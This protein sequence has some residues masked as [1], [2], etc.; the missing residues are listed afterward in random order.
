M[1]TLERQKTFLGVK[2]NENNAA[3]LNKFDFLLFTIGILCCFLLFT[4]EDIVTTGCNSLSY[5]QGVPWKFYSNNFNWYNGYAANY[6]PTI[7]LLFSIWN[8]PLVCLNFLLKK[9]VGVAILSSAW[10]CESVWVTYY[11]KL[12]P[13]LVFFLTGILL[14]RLCVQRLSFS[15][16]KAQICM[17]VFYTSPFAFFSQFVFCQYDILTVFFMV[18]GLFYYFEERPTEKDYAWFSLFFGIAMS[19]KYFAAVFWAALILVRVKDIIQIIRNGIICVAPFVIEATVYIIFDRQKFV[20]NVFNFPALDFAKAGF[21]I[22]GMLPI[23]LMPLALILMLAIAY[24]KEPKTFD[25][26]VHTALF[27]ACGCCFCFFGLMTFYPQ[28]LMLGVIFWTLG[29]C[30]HQHPEKFI[31]IDTFAYVAL[32]IFAVNVFK[33]GVDETMLKRGVL[34]HWL[35]FKTE[36]PVTMADIFSKLSSEGMLALFYTCFVAALLVGFIFRH[37]CYGVPLKEDNSSKELI[38]A[39]RIRLIVTVLFFLLPALICFPGMLHADELLWSRMEKSHTSQETGEFFEEGI[40]ISKKD[41]SEVLQVVTINGSQIKKIEIPFYVIVNQTSDISVAVLD[42][43][44]SVLQEGRGTVSTGTPTLT[45]EFSDSA[46][47]TPGTQYVIRVKVTGSEL[48]DSE[49]ISLYRDYNEVVWDSDTAVIDYSNDYAMWNDFVQS[50]NVC[51][52]II[53]E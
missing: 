9:T 16:A 51:M 19:C 27:V 49:C 46:T 7:F 10:N 39:L 47:L 28:W 52:S 29:T 40:D 1:K 42:L 20:A 43:N 44:G 4:H 5:W 36:Y 32:V 24:F 26:M 17:A 30:V 3:N 13:I 11:F 41:R 35:Q 53:G 6:M 25:E 18:C 21:E 50:Y 48:S 12:F 22:V 31:W 34:S 14:Y 33:G 8:F 45:V 38:F 15:K 2:Q 23:R 37:P